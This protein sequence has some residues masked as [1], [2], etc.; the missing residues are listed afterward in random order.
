MRGLIITF[1]TML[2]AAAVVTAAR[3]GS[4]GACGTGSGN[5]TATRTAGWLARV[6]HTAGF[7]VHGCT[8]SAWVVGIRR[9]EIYLWAARGTSHAPPYRRYRRKLPLPTF[10]DGT[11]IEWSVQRMRIWIEPGPSPTDVVPDAR[12]IA[13]LQAASRRVAAQR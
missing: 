7:S 10:T 11:R 3:S 9:G 13:A 5:W 2:V 8:G 4:A 12:A 6:V 1:M